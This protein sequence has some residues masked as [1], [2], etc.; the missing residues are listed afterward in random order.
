MSGF[1]STRRW[2]VSAVPVVALAAASLVGP[3]VVRA[4]DEVAHPAHI[5]AGTCEELGDVVVPLTDVTLP[6]TAAT[7]PESA[8]AVKISDTFVP[9]S[10][11]EIVAGGHAINVHESA[12]NI[13]E[14][15]ACG[16][17]G[18]AVENGR[19]II[20][21]GELND[22][23]HTGVAALIA[24]QGGTD[25]SIFLV[26]DEA[27]AAFDAAEGGATPEAA[28]GGT[29]ADATP[30]AAAGDE[31]AAAEGAAVTIVDFAY[32]P[33]EIT[34]PVGGTVT[35]TNDD[36][37]PHTATAQDRDALQSGTI[38][39]GSSFEQSFDTAGTYD[40]FCEFHPNMQGT[41]VVE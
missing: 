6:V 3:S 18:G 23:G 34:V 24:V 9:L 17:V 28:V 19:L 26:E 11:E 37:A 15:I 22:S 7:G 40:Y 39:P 25:V 2:L 35:W 33:A 30:E 5:H 38:D 31:A 12:E 10:I 14:Y 29:D 1:V 36:A 21:L 8:L 4:Q 13:G 20:G 16:A 32:D 41:I 27:S